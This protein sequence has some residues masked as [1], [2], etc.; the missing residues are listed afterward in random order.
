MNK[1]KLK[2]LTGIFEYCRWLDSKITT[3][4]TE[5][6]LPYKDFELNMR[7]LAFNIVNEQ[8]CLEVTINNLPD[9]A[10]KRGK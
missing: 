10:I 8:I 7:I 5:E 2:D 9:D 4:L 1:T 3:V 6:G